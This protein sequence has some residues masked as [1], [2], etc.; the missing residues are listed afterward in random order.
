MRWIAILFACSILSACDE[1]HDTMVRVATIQNGQVWWIDPDFKKL[2]TALAACRADPSGAEDECDL[3]EGEA[4]SAAEGVMTCLYSDLPA[5]Q[6]LVRRYGLHGYR[7][8]DWLQV[9]ST[10]HP[11]GSLTAI[12]HDDLNTLLWPDNPLI[13]SVWGWSDRAGVLR[14]R[15]Q[16]YH[17]PIQLLVGGIVGLLLLWG[18]MTIRRRHH[19][20]M[21]IAQRRT[22]EAARVAKMR[23]EHERVALLEKEVSL[24]RYRENERVNALL[25]ELT[26]ARQQIEQ[27]QAEREL[28]LAAPPPDA[29]PSPPDRESTVEDQITQAFR[30]RR[31]N[32]KKK[33]FHPA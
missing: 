26:E 17:R 12:P 25:N 1:D 7:F 16:K 27:L 32:R 33:A 30:N 24:K 4:W 19:Q 23:I 6:I 15:Y 18:I 21:A 2:D 20:R 3:R 29:P 31:R 8:N 14:Q 9:L 13:R 28:L 10:V 22:A 11:S 5:C